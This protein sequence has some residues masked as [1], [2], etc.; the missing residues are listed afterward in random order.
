M[1]HPLFFRHASNGYLAREPQG[2]AD[3]IIALLA[4]VD[5]RQA[6]AE[7]AFTDM[8]QHTG[9]RGF[10]DAVCTFLDQLA[11]GPP[12]HRSQENR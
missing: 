3:A 2:W 7:Q 12:T 9:I 4:S 10:A 1:D 8:Q 6:V 11:P 5:H